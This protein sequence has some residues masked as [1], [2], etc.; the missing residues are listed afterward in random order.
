[1]HIRQA[2]FT[3]AA[4]IIATAC[5]S[6]PAAFAGTENSMLRTITVTGAGEASAVPDMAVISIGVRTQAA[7]AGAAL[8]QNSA[9]MRATLDTLD[10]LGVAERDIQTSGLS[11]NPRYDYE[12]NRSNPPII[13][14]TA[15]NNVTVKLRDLDKTGEII[16]QTVQ[17]GANSLG[18][19]SFTFSDSKPLYDAARKDAVKAGAAKAALLTDAAGVNLGRLLTIS[20]G[21]IAAPSPRMLVTGARLDAEAAVPVAAGEST[22]RANVTLIYE[23]N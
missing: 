2:I 5:A 15:S 12:R 13:G 10:D 17:S 20:D 22:V 19:I 23:I 9:A 11:L 21:H 18:G 3:S 8:R 4:I 6:P 7:T 16:D 14:Y 1:M